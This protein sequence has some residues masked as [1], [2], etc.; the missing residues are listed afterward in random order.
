MGC[1]LQGVKG[2]AGCFVRDSKLLVLQSVEP[3]CGHGDNSTPS[4]PVLL[5]TNESG[6]DIIRTITLTNLTLAPFTP[7]PV[8][9]DPA[10]VV[11]LL[12]AVVTVVLGSYIANSPF[13]F[14]RYCV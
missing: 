6:W 7:H 4:I 9:F 12:I 2:A 5:V 1:S 3:V 8:P 14:M 10:A 13:E 11:T